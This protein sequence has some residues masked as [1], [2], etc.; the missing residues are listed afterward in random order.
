MLLRLP[1]SVRGNG[2]TLAT[3]TEVGQILE[4]AKGEPPLSLAE[5]G[6]RMRAKRVRHA[7]IRATVDFL[8]QLGFV[9]MGSKGVQWTHT[10]D[11]R[12]WTAARKGSSLLEEA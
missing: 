9:T 12:F 3:L 6:R 4:A 7:T 8:A 1:E 11:E 5:V 10:R 2:P